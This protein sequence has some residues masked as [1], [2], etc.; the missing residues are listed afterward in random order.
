MDSLVTLSEDLAAAT[1]QAGRAVFAVHGRPRVPSTGTHWRPGLLVTANHTVRVD[2]DLTVTRPDGQTV[3]ATIV[4]RDAALDIALLR[5]AAPDVPVADVGDSDGVRV[6]HIVLALGAG[7]RVSWGVVSVIE[8][9]PAPGTVGDVF[10]LDLTLY[11][12][13]SGGPLVDTRGSVVGLNTSGAA[14]HLQFAIPANVVGRVVDELERHG[15]IPRAYLGVGTQQ[16]RVPEAFRGEA[17]GTGRTAVIVVDVQPGSPAA[18]TLLIGDVLLSLDGRA[19]ADPFELRALLRSTR[20]GQRVAASVV[21][22]GQRLD[23]QLTIGE[24]PERTR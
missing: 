17:G 21:R 12:G 10:G 11:P 22:A 8:G 24:R 13:F 2:D 14:R 3:S 1:H 16:V 4:G 23:L 7:P 9:G 20:I 6:G 15:R 19:I 5:I 18:N